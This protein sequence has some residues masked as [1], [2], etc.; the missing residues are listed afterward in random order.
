MSRRVLVA[1]GDS[2]RADT[3]ARAFSEQGFSVRTVAHGAAALEA[4]LE[5]VPDAVV[6]Q[7]DL[8]LIT[9]FRLA[10]IL[11]A[12]P[13]TRAAK[14]VYLGDTSADAE[15]RDLGG[16]VLVPPVHPGAVLT[17]VEAEL[18]EAPEN[19]S[20]GALAAD[21]AGQLTQ[22]PLSDVLELFHVSRK[23]GA[24]EVVRGLGRT[25]RQ[26]GRIVL[27]EGDVI[28]ASIGDT[29]GKKALF[30]LL[31][32]NQGSFSFR[33]GP[34]EGAA[35]IATPTRALLS[36]GLRQVREWERIAVDL[37]PMGATVTLGAQAEA[38]AG[39]FH[40]LTREVLGA[41]SRHERVEDV[42]DACE[43][44]D[45][46]VLRTLQALIQR[47]LVGTTPE[48]GALGLARDLEFF[49]A[50]HATR[51]REWLELDRPGG[52]ARRDAK[53]VVL[54]AH[55]ETLRDFVAL[56]ARLPGAV[57]DDRLDVGTIGTEDLTVLGTVSVD[58]EVGLEFV[59]VPSGDTFAPIW[60]VAGHGALATVVLLASPLGLAVAEVR[61]ACA[62]LA[63]GPSAR[64]FHLLLL[65]KDERPTPEEL[66]ANL[67]VADETSLFLLP[68]ENSERADVLMREL[69]ERVL[70]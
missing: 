14:L 66:R 46:Q 45:Y 31:T 9:G 43:A 56:L 59:H 26:V 36:E 5:D 38:L 68:L 37:P 19:P 3:I 18:G 58:A 21:N 23:T 8:P 20:G 65:G 44:P 41:L 27:R 30:R 64:T 25:R 47:G 12:N 32:W 51:L 67:A 15:R 50:E 16:P 69:L 7:L 54:S 42:V 48:P 61:A 13:R 33:P 29:K 11:R 22:L 24:V 28:D 10:A 55:S 34:I 63:S 39:D 1:D 2:G 4:A 35:G 57:L 53:V 52:L 40:P 49:D 62:Q 70:P 17:C 60:P 6:C